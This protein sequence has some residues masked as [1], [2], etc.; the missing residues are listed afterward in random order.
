MRLVEKDKACGAGKER[1]CCVGKVCRRE[2][3]VGTFIPSSPSP[4]PDEFQDF[5][6]PSSSLIFF[7]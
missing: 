3:E 2:V 5:A 7:V 6:S 1:V 4:P